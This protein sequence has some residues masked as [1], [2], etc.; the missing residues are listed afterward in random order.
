MDVVQRSVFD[1]L[2]KQFPNL[3]ALKQADGLIS[4]IENNKQSLLKKVCSN[5]CRELTLIC[6]GSQRK[7]LEKEFP[8][9]IQTNIKQ[10]RDILRQIDGLAADREKLR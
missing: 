5:L 10:L 3:D 8:H 4:K 6:F 2:N 7:L 1:F 9:T